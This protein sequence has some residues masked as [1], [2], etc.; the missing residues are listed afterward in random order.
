MAQYRFNYDTFQDG[1]VPRSVTMKAKSG[2][3]YNINRNKRI[4]A[5]T[6]ATRNVCAADPSGEGVVGGE[7]VLTGPGEPV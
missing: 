7:M 5:S 4:N 1:E 2:P 6:Q 3:C